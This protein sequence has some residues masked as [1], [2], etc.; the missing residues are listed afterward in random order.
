MLQIGVT[1]EEVGIIYAVLPFASCLGPP[2]AGENAKSF[3]L[4]MYLRF[5]YSLISWPGQHYCSD[6]GAPTKTIR[7]TMVSHSWL[8]LQQYSTILRIPTICSCL[9]QDSH[10]ISSKLI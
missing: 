2:V 5:I 10:V 3:I 7:K 8:S 6:N 1:I 9:V 4:C